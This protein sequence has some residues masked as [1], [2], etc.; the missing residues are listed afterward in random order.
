MKMPLPTT[1]AEK[2][3]GELLGIFVIVVLGI[4]GSILQKIVQRAERKKAEEQ[5]RLRQQQGHK[6]AT[7]SRQSAI[8][9]QL[10]EQAM[11]IMGIEPV[12]PTVGEDR[13]QIIVET[14]VP[15]ARRQV[16]IPG[17]VRIAQPAGIAMR[18]QPAEPEKTQSIQGVTER[19]A[20]TSA[21]AVKQ[22]LAAPAGFPF[23][24]ADP[25]R[26]RQAVM[27]YEIISS[28]RALRCEDQPWEL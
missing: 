11:R 8:D 15:P 21:S 10:A 24:L 23:D 22:A 20:G 17:A 27:M 7:P 25:E 5:Y 6:P 18:Q 9:Q 4:V 13:Y 19:R 14:P 12:P 1:L 28:P 2:D 26:A 16:A 3:L